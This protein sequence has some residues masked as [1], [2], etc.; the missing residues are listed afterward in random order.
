MTTRTFGWGI[1]VVLALFVLAGMIGG[2][3]KTPGSMKSET[4]APTRVQLGPAP[5]GSDAMVA[6]EAILDNFSKD[7]CSLVI[8]AKRFGDGSIR[9]TCNTG[10][11]FRIFT[12]NGKAMAMRCS[13]LKR[14]GLEGC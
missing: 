5:E 14:L 12:L 2:T 11:V 7:D 4:T 10:E 1:I 13:A 3:V 9:A 8:D 6:Q